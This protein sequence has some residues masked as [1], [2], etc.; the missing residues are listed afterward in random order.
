MNRWASTSAHGTSVSAVVS[1]A[2]VTGL[3]FAFA[4]AKIVQ[5]RRKPATTGREGLIGHTAQVRNR[6]DPD[7]T[8][9]VRGELWAA[10]SLE[11]SIDVGQRVIVENA[12][13]FRLYV[14]PAPEE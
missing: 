14:R 12:E 4:V 13:G 6:L 2:V 11:G 9:V 10:T 7:G 5:I 3:F 1:V 8:V